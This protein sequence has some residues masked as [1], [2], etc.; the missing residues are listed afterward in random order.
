VSAVSGQ[1]TT[2]GADM[3]EKG[4]ITSEEL[5][6]SLLHQTGDTLKAKVIDKTSDAAVETVRE[7]LARRGEEPGPTDVPTP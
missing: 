5:A 7:R 2:E 3:G 4:N 1:A 6:G